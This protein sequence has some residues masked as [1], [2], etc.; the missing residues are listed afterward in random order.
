MNWPYH[1]FVVDM[2]GLVPWKMVNKHVAV[3]APRNEVLKQFP[4]E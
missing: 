4:F 1:F 2:V 3:D